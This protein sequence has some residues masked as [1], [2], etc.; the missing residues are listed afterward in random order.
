MYKCGVFDE[1]YQVCDYLGF[2][3]WMDQLVKK[4]KLLK[5]CGNV[6][7][8]YLMR[9]NYNMYFFIMMYISNLCGWF[10]LFIWNFFMNIFFEYMNNFSFN[11]KYCV[12]CCQL[13]DQ[14]FLVVF[15]VIDMIVFK[16]LNVSEDL[17]IVSVVYGIWL[18]K[19]SF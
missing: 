5:C 17:I 4:K 2:V 15:F 13:F 14:C 7:N 10:F 3:I 12:V 9:F 6:F 8:Y 1:C 19:C 16:L 18:I 11:N